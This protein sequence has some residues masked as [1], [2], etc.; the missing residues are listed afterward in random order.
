M[1]VYDGTRGCTKR[2]HDFAHTLQAVTSISQARL[3]AAGRVRA[4]IRYENGNKCASAR[5]RP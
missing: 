3:I 4:S 2:A 5:A 1:L